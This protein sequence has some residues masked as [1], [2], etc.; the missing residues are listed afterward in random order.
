MKCI[1]YQIEKYPFVCGLYAL[2]VQNVALPNS[3]MCVL[4]P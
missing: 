2:W 4:K 1:D 3:V